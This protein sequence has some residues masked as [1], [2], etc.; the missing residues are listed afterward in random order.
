MDRVFRF[1][2]THSALP[3]DEALMLAV[4]QA[5]MNP[6]RVLGLPAAGLVPGATADLVVLN[7]DLAVIGV[8]RGGSW[9]VEPGLTA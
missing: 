7:S 4:R 3:R 2:V 6:A 1:A 5:S 8:L 9:V